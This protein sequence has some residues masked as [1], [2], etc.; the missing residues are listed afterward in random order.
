MSGIGEG[1]EG[2]CVVR[3][4]LKGLYV[5]QDDTGDI[6]LVQDYRVMILLRAFDRSCVCYSLE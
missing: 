1:G 4:D 5:V 2:L 3:K 6:V